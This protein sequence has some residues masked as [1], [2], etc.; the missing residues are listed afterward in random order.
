MNI[1]MISDALGGAE[2]EL[3]DTID[4]TNTY[5]KR[6]ADT[7][8]EGH[9][10]IALS[11]SGGRGRLGRTFFSP[12]GTGLYMSILLKPTLPADKAV[13][14]TAA[15]AVAAAEAIEKISNKKTDIKWV[16]DVYI[17]GKKVCGILTEAAFDD[18]GMKYAVLGIGINVNVPEGGFPED[19]KNI[20]GS[21]FES[22]DD[23]CVSHLVTELTE[24]FFAY[25]RKL[26]KME[27]LDTYKAKM[28]YIGESIN[29]ISPS[30]CYTARLVS[31]NDDFSLNVRTDS[32]EDKR[33][34]SGEIS[35]RKN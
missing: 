19:I 23:E 5:L 20:A 35:I 4:S 33:I 10:V 14:I 17:G 3:F 26:E 28:M 32:D 24:K 15:A 2:V 29:V 21:V 18:A 25:Y 30:E 13:Y 31:V 11:Q 7:A 34:F 12:A 1:E 22:A 8:S 16:N 6:K 9:T 27:Y